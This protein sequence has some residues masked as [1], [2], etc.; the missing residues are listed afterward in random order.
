MTSSGG[1][2]LSPTSPAR[3]PS[4]TRPPRLGRRT[5]RWRPRTKAIAAKNDALDATRSK[6][7]SRAAASRSDRAERARSSPRRSPLLDV[8]P[9]QSLQLALQS[10]SMASTPGLEDTLRDG[11]E[12]CPRPR[13]AAERERDG[14]CDRDE[15][16]RSACVRRPVERE[17]HGRRAADERGRD[18]RARR[19]R[20]RRGEGLRARDPARRLAAAPARRAAPGRG[21]LA[22]REVRLH[23]RR[24]RRHHSVGRPQRRPARRGPS[25]ARRSASSRCRPTAGSSPRRRGRRPACGARPTEVMSRGCRIPLS[26]EGVSFSPSGAQLLTLAR[27][28]AALRHARLGARPDRAR[29]AGADPDRGLLS[30]RGSRRDRRPR[31]PGDDLGRPGRHP[32]AHARAPRRRARRRLVAERQ[33]ARHGE[34][35]QR[36]PCLPHRHRRALHVPRRAFEPGRRRRLQ[37]GRRV[38]RDRVP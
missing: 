24:Q 12:Q 3:T 9:E 4:G 28:A 27:D 31:R 2:G 30:G 21:L 5:P 16:E 20:G 8:N 18:A 36:W 15:L 23:R 6:R 13:G 38:D 11:V 25:T 14:Q 10:A 34:R 7:R 29:P 33:P 22:G 26:V 35:G 37:P 1:S 17:R 19:R 32:A